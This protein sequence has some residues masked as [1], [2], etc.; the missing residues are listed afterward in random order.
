MRIYNRYIIYHLTIPT[1]VI[2]LTLTG[3]I[4]LTQSLRFID[5]IVNRGLDVLTFLYLSALLIPSLLSIII[6]VA[7][8]CSILYTYNRL[9]SDSELI[10]LKAAGLSKIALAKPAFIVTIFA[11]IFC[12]I[13]TLYLLPSSYSKFKDTQ[14]LARNNYA[15]AL[16]QEGVF[17]TPVK[18]LTVYIEAIN[19][20]GTFHGIL[21]HDARKSE[22]PI[23]MM[24]E[25]GKLLK[26]PQGPQFYLENG[27]RQEINNQ[28][29][30]L[31]MLYFESFP[32]DLGNYTNIGE[33]TFREPE[34][35]YITE[36][37]SANDVSEATRKKF[38]AEG[39]ERIL[40]PL[41]NVALS[42]IALAAISSG[43]FNR[44]G[45]WKRILT[46]G[47]IATIVMS[48]SITF[49]SLIIYNH[50]LAWLIYG[51][52]LTLILL[53]FASLQNNTLLT[54]VLQQQQKK[55]K[56]PDQFPAHP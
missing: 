43:Q 54:K 15:S 26:T 37:F 33:R 34:E 24:A 23:T 11:T 47:I 38:I 40:W 27:S 25:K 56:H 5:L 44:R 4:W 22:A 2:T 10:V 53:C 46:A 30:N 48:S 42:F 18:N 32:M 12:Y 35:R 21:V 7:L 6:P 1:I 9:T 51:M 16:L 50:H 41:Y 36:L 17:N 3:I 8:F 29:G 20:D 52:L 14:F 28:T 49:K 45:L 19:R 13:I 39:H 55:P 31:S